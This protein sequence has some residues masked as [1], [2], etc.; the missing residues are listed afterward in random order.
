ML[1]KWQGISHIFLLA[2]LLARSQHASGKDL[3]P[4]ISANIF[5]ISFPL[6]ENAEMLPKYRISTVYYSCSPPE[7]NF[8]DIISVA[9]KITTVIFSQ[10][11]RSINSENE[12]CASLSQSAASSLHF[13][14][15]LISRTSGISPG[16]SNRTKLFFL[17]TI[18]CLTY[19]RTFHFHLL[20]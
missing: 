20:F 7:L 2:G 10:I 8:S 1:G 15:A 12:N 14:S 6:Q 4:P 5:L 9:I 13:H 17:P 11:I 19:P 16:T 18:K 3:L